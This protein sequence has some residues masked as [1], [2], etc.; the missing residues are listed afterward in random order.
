MILGKVNQLDSKARRRENRTNYWADACAWA[1]WKRP[2]R[3]RS[4]FQLNCVVTSSEF[5]IAE[6]SCDSQTV[7]AAKN[8]VEKKTAGT[9]AVERHR[10]LMNKLSDADLRRLHH[11][12]AELFYGGETAPAGR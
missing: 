1:G 5:D 11:R 3:S 9:L 6:F 8:F 2:G 10:P 7:K 12:A 4:Q